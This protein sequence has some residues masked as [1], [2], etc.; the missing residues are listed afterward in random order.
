MSDAEDIDDFELVTNARML[1]APP[2]LRNTR[3]V[4]KDW[5]LQSGKSAGFLAWEITAGDYA[6]FL[7]SG[8]VYKNGVFVRYENKDEDVRFLAFSLRDQHGNRLW[9]RVEA[10]KEVL[11]KL[12][13]G[14]INLLIAAANKVNAIKEAGKAGNS[15]ETELDS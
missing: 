7:E 3:V 14:D 9:S 12:G 15:E 6:E 10:A 2:E 1:T 4:M 5:K 8:R 11:D 13:K